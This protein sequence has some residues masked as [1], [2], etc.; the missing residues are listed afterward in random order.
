MLSLG[1]VSH[2]LP[3]LRRDGQA[4]HDYV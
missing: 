3:P 4:A 1:H 2:T